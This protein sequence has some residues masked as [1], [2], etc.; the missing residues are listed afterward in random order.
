MRLPLCWWKL[1]W[2]ANQVP[3]FFG[4]DIILAKKIWMKQVPFHLLITNQ[5]YITLYEFNYP[6][7]FFHKSS[8]AHG[9]ASSY[10]CLVK[11]SV[12]LHF[13]THQICNAHRPGTKDTIH[14]STANRQ[15]STSKPEFS[16]Q[17]MSTATK[18]ELQFMV[19]D[20]IW[21]IWAIQF[22]PHMQE[23]HLT[24]GYSSLYKLHR[25]NRTWVPYFQLG[26]PAP[27]WITVVLTISSDA[28]LGCWSP[29]LVNCKIRPRQTLLIPLVYG[30]L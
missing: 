9:I 1:V 7:S 25:C 5:C 12:S 16:T 28:E 14:F 6:V 30:G 8:S 17:A 19:M 21:W 23:I 15:A 27:K 29:I 13:F 4:H 10:H 22:D 20:S 24:C 3:G 18:N 2:E 11:V 26:V